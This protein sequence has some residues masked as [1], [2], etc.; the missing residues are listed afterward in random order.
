MSWGTQ[1]MNRGTGFIGLTLAGR[2]PR[3][4]EYPVLGRCRS[5]ACTGPARLRVGRPRTA[6]PAGYQLP[7][8]PWMVTSWFAWQAP[9][10][11]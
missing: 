4:G 11:N 10:L 9:K 1:M 2:L 7:W 6:R 3:Q 8:P 5:R